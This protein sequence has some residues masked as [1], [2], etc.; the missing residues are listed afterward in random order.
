ML[1]KPVAQARV[2]VCGLGYYELHLNGRK[3][4]DHVLGVRLGLGQHVVRQATQLD[5]VLVDQRLQGVVPVP[6]GVDDQ[7]RRS[8]VGERELHLRPIDLV[9]DVENA[10][11]GFLEALGLDLYLAITAGRGLDRRDPGKTFG[12][13]FGGALG[14]AEAAFRDALDRDP[15]LGAAHH[16]LAAV[17]T[18]L[19][20]PEDAIREYKDALERGVD[21][22]MING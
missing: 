18:R 6:G 22:P 4:G 16:N 17:Y 9:G 14:D 11:Q 19:G 20:K 2:Y 7:R 12:E 15:G 10:H 5:V 1:S 8:G 3:L 21:L 13:V